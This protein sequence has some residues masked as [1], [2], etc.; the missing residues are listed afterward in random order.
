MKS[1]NSRVVKKGKLQVVHACRKD[2]IAQGYQ[3][4]ITGDVIKTHPLDA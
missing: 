1:D 2:K 3:V 4:A